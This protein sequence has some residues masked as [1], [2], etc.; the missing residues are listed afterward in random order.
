MSVQIPTAFVEQ[1][2][3]N[4][5]HLTQQNGSRLRGCVDVESVVGKNAYFEQIGLTEMVEVTSRHADTP[6]VDVPHSRR[7][8]SLKDFKWSELVD[9]ADK[10]RLLIDPASPYAE[11]AARAAG[12]TIDR[13]IIAAADSVAFTGVDGSTS[14][15]F[16]T[17]MIVG[18]QERW[19]AVTA[20]NYGLN[21]AKLVKAMELLGNNNVDVDDEK[22]MVV[23]SRQIG[24]LMKDTR[25]V[26]SDYNT[27]KPLADG[28]VVKYYGF[29]IIPTQL[30]GVDGSGFDKC[31]FWARGGIKLGMGDDI[32]TRIGERADKN[33]ST[34]VF[35]ALT[36]GA[37]RMEE[38][39]VGYV[40]CD[41]TAG[42]GA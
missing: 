29:N 34:Q 36:L 31:L 28:K 20:A 26:S 16:D 42:P 2:K 27:L 30:I 25:H 10:I 11:A 41:T 7:R 24:S 4:V 23:N 14:T 5:Y 17:N 33:Y 9:D 21:V 13:T 32:K 6:R 1:Y 18:V 3:A 15:P 40:T 37:T 12:R 35:C 38:A 19:P 8:L 39:R 22:Y